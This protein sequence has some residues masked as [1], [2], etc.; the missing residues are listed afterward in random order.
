MRN[1]TI[2][3]NK[4][5]VGCLVKMK[6]YISDFSSN[7]ITINN[8]PCRKLGDLKNGEEKTFAIDNGDA[9][10]FVIADRLSKGFCNEFYNIT[11]GDEDIYLSGQNRYN[12]A[13]GI[14]F[15]FDGVT[16]EEILK[17]R[18][19]GNKIGIIVLIAAFIV[20]ILIGL[21]TSSG[22]FPPEPQTFTSNGMSITL[23]DE[24]FETEI[25]NYTVCFDSQEVAVF[26]LKEEFSLVEG[27]G[28]YSLE[29]YRDLVLQSNGLDS[30]S[31]VSADGTSYF[32]YEF[33]NPETG[34]NYS[35]Y[36]FVYKAD[37]AFW[38]VQF[39][40]LSENKDEYV[41]SFIEWSKTVKFA[42]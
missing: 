19:K 12:P 20:G 22:L 4:S 25:E 13:N 35:Y 3:R 30:S 18:K 1:L 16:D 42:K 24:F 31:V 34:D 38:L 8:I 41:P 7:E 23:T 17:N 5:F 39:A 15:R 32:S 11:A 37:D 6:I 33:K 27:F 14:A 36:S 10:I 29:Q 28:D 2:K 26:A 40:T 9:R 21:A